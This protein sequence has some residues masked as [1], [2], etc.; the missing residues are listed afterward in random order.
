VSVFTFFE[1]VVKVILFKYTGRNDLSVATSVSIRDSL[2]T[3]SMVG[4][5][6]K[7]LPIIS[8]IKDDTPFNNFLK[9]EDE[10]IKFALSNKDSDLD[11]IFGENI[12]L[13]SEVII[14]YQKS[15]LFNLTLEGFDVTQLNFD[16]PVSKFKLSWNFFEND[17]EMKF[18]VGYNLR[19]FDEDFCNQISKHFVNLIK[20][21]LEDDNTICEE[22]TYL[23]KTD[24]DFKQNN[25]Y[26]MQSDNVFNLWDKLNEYAE[27]KPNE[28]AIVDS[29][30][31]I[32][33]KEL[34]ERV[35]GVSNRLKRYEPEANSTIPLH[36]NRSIDMI[37]GMLGILQSGNAYSPIDPDLPLKRKKEIIS[38][39]DAKLVV[40]NIEFLV[41][42]CDILDLKHVS[43][44]EVS[45]ANVDPKSNAYVLFTS[46]S[47]GKPKGVI[48]RNENL[49]NLVNGLQEFYLDNCIERTAL[50]APYYFDASI[51][52]IFPSLT[53]GKTLYVTE[54]ET[55][56]NG[57]EL[58]I[59]LDKNKINL[60][61]ATL[62]H[63]QMMSLSEG[64]DLQ[65]M[66]TILVGGEALKPEIVES[67]VEKVNFSKS[68]I[69]NVYGPTECT[70]VVAYY[71]L[72]DK[73]YT[74]IP[75]GR[76]LRNCNL[77]V[78]NR[79]GQELSRHIPG[80]LIISGEQVG[81]GY[82]KNNNLTNTQFENDFYK[83]GDVVYRGS[84]DN[85]YF[86]G[87]K[88]KQ[89]KLNGFRIEPGE[90]ET[91]LRQFPEIDSA[92][93]DKVTDLNGNDQLTAWI[94][95]RDQNCDYTVSQVISNDIIDENLLKK[96]MTCKKSI[97]TF[98]ALDDYD[99][100]RYKRQMMLDQWNEG[101]QERL[102]SATVF[103]AGAGGI[104]SPVLMQLA[105]LGV[106]NII[107][108]D[109]D[110]V[111]LSN[112]NRQFMHNDSRIGMNKAES[113]KLTIQ[114]TNPKI[115]VIVHKERIT[116]DNIKRL[117]ANADLIFDCVD[118][119][120][121]KF[122]LSECAVDKSIPHI[123]MVMMEINSYVS[124][125][126]P[127]FSPCL[128]C[129]YDFG[130]MDE[131]KEMKS[132]TNYRKSLSNPVS[133]PALFACTGFAMNEAI[134]IIA[135]TDKPAYGKFFLFNQKASESITDALGYQI[136]VFP[137]SKY[138]KDQCNDSGFS[139]DLG[140]SGKILEE[141]DVTADPNCSQ[142]STLADKHE[143]QNA[144][145][146]TD[147]SVIVNLYDNTQNQDIAKAF[148]LLGVNS[149]ILD[150]CY[151][152][153]N[154]FQEYNVRQII[155][156]KLNYDY[157]TEFTESYNSNIDVLI[158]DNLAF[159]KNEQT[160]NKGII[161]ELVQNDSG[162]F[163]LNVKDSL[164]E[165]L[166]KYL[167]PQNIVTV[168]K[169]PLTANGKIDLKTL[170][171]MG[172]SSNKTKVEPTTDNEKYLHDLWCELLNRN[173]ISITDDFFTIGGNS[174][175][176]VQMVFRIEKEQGV[177]L[178]IGDIFNN[179]VIKDLAKL[180]TDKKSD[181]VEIDICD[182][183]IEFLDAE[184]IEDL[185]KWGI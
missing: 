118:D 88:D 172:T 50:V 39:L 55:R 137:F 33:W 169:F 65:S 183:E 158:W 146:E 126:H 160:E 56:L 75:I 64:I 179:P 20:S 9:F 34:Q 12:D 182:D 144:S 90:I 27:S 74:R 66:Q 3:S 82:W 53:F 111:D 95:K 78:V 68:K 151:R 21:I 149:L 80:E 18:M 23:S 84:D 37:I 93:V 96:A 32:T 145:I 19:Y 11:E 44:T 135:K 40:S 177:K 170:A 141:I 148:S 133:A 166:P 98:K 77:K 2:E 38:E 25:S 86:A 48:I 152:N 49:E 28:P 150:K 71:R 8:K 132:S 47:T 154:V 81:S 171:N 109:F 70:D 1:A 101:S 142:C 116:R 185:E 103:V 130:K 14:Q 57:V 122:V 125:L 155:T 63:L 67:F 62:A 108:T 134:K 159:S 131:I 36:T 106:G 143:T 97:K 16:Y 13:L 117:V 121:T 138:F 178:K 184:D 107:I 60:C 153:E 181:F 165:S 43:K 46:G 136:L 15:D 52:T 31:S 105:L 124:I 91:K 59:F 110:E 128:K 99:R 147:Y 7:M 94:V 10:N 26:E 17:G 72:E 100:E 120:E 168:E 176:A 92:I 61:D 115:N 139:W 5:L 162:I 140:F 87:R 89:L 4:L 51:K 164:K 112:L 163:E 175:I 174:I 73:Y 123:L 54:E 24:L 69:I 35:L 102:K 129:I 45:L 104:G 157:W 119:L 22:L 127:P 161:Q 173:S 156:D 113:A 85:I 79:W 83:T 42:N 41:N 180:W 29:N 114:Q 167:I 30:R 6:I 58:A 76:S